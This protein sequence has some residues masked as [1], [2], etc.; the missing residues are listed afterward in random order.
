[1]AL[2]FWIVVL[3]LS[4]PMLAATERTFSSRNAT[5]GELIDNCTTVALLYPNYTRCQ[6]TLKCIL[7]NIDSDY[8][9]RWSAGAS[10]LA[11]IPTIA[12]LMSNSLD[13]VVLAAE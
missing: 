11:F 12:G 1:M 2:S 6:A 3:F 8:S 5:V 10:I 7:T 13:E 9:A 4:M